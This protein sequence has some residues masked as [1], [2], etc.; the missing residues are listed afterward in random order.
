MLLLSMSLDLSTTSFS[1]KYFDEMSQSA[2]V[3]IPRVVG[4]M[5]HPLPLT[6]PPQ[7]A[8]DNIFSC[9]CGKMVNFGCQLD[10]AMKHLN[11]WLNIIMYL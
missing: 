5:N 4:N 2:R 6:I 11:I 1:H 8:R 10:W 7:F 9:L 3:A